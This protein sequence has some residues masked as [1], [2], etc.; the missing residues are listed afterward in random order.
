MAASSVAAAALAGCAIPRREP[1]PLSVVSFGGGFNLPLWAARDQGFFARHGLAATLEVTPDSRNVFSGLMEG[2]YHVAITAFD[3]IVAYQEGQGELK[4]DPPS[5]FFAFMG[6]DDGFL[7][8]VAVPEVKSVRELRG[9][10]VSVDAM[11]NGFSFALREML[12]RNGVAESE[13][14]W[15]RAG[16]TDRR[17][18]ALME[19]QHDATMLRAPFDLLAKNRGFH[20]LATAREVLGPYLGIVGAARRSWAQQHPAAVVGFIRAYRDAVRWL[21]EPANRPAAQALLRA[22]VPGMS[23]QIAQQSC[24]LM[25]DPR[26][27]FFPD[28]GLD[29]EA[30]RAVLALRGKLG[31]PPRTLDDPDKYLDRRYWREATAG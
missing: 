14:Q 28:V 30:V 13:V 1:Q 24:A 25:L 26:S 7:S 18:A 27:G 2:R 21:E 8:L 10:T 17:F 3:N 15:A 4:F 23:E 9:R 22:N 19:R 6:S 29:P 16:G 5:D 11:S 31:E 12:A 20:Q